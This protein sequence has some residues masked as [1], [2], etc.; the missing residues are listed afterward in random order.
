VTATQ[1]GNPGNVFTFTPISCGTSGSGSIAQTSPGIFTVIA[2]TT[3]N[4]TPCS[5]VITGLG[6]K[7]A[8]LSMTF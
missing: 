3:S 8:S 1:S 4:G 7:T 2:Q 5:S 6:Y